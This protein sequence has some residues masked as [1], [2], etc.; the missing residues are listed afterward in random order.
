[1]RKPSLN[2][3]VQDTNIPVKILKEKADYFAGHI[4][5]QFNEAV[6][7]LKFSTSFKFAYMTPVFKQGCRNQED[8]YKPTGMVTI[9]SRILK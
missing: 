5:L 7:W 2:K 8:N 4:C 9:V 6:C 3:A 1:M